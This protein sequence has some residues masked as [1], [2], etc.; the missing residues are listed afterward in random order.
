[1]VKLIGMND[2]DIYI[3]IYIYQMNAL[4]CHER[5]VERLINYVTFDV[6]DIQN[7]RKPLPFPSET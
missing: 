5:E 6:T 7:C 3:Y 1:M 2:R 4:S